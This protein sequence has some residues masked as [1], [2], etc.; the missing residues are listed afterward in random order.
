MG[1]IDVQPP[2]D[3]STMTHEEK[4]AWADE[5]VGA[6]RVAYEAEDD[7]TPTT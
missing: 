2:R 3:W 1:R 7:G 5:I 4:L 6:T